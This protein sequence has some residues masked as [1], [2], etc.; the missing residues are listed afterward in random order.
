M[1]NTAGIIWP[2]LKGLCLPDAHTTLES[3]CLSYESNPSTLSMSMTISDLH[4]SII[5]CIYNIY[6]CKY[7][8]II[9]HN[10]SSNLFPTGSHQLL[11]QDAKSRLEAN[12]LPASQE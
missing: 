6:V 7:I 1:K 2:Q 10:K 11:F 3:L 9:V 5:F 8:Y 12:E 4:H